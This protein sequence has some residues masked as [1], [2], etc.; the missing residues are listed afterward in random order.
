MLDVNSI[1]LALRTLGS[2]DFEGSLKFCLRMCSVL[3]FF[4]HLGHSLTQFVRHCA[5]HFL[6]SEHKE[7][8]LEAV[9]TCSRLLTPSLNV[10]ETS[11]I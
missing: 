5:E 6:A 4:S 1:T 2:F 10:R 3:S 9:R 11:D 7:I 8:R